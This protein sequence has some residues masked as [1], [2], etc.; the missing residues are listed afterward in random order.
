MLL[1]LF[2]SIQDLAKN[3]HY[4]YVIYNFPIEFTVLHR[5]LRTSIYIQTQPG[6]LGAFFKRTKNGTLFENHDVEQ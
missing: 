3:G 6:A 5:G 1:L 2:N 4:V